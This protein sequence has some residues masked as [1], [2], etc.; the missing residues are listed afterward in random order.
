MRWKQALMIASLLLGAVPVGSET[1]SYL[2]AGMT[3]RFNESEQ[4]HPKVGT[5]AIPVTATTTGYNGSPLSFGAMYRTQFRMEEESRNSKGKVIL[6]IQIV[7]NNR[8]LWQA[9]KKSRIKYDGY[10]SNECGNCTHKLK[11]K[12]RF[13][14]NLQK[15]DLVLFQFKFKGMPR[16]QIGE[17][18]LFGGDVY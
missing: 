11:F 12:N 16:F 17:T 1:H 8:V 7:R 3:F 6:Q 18:A 14:G 15:G 10:T 4:K 9:K 2:S 5:L 13:Q